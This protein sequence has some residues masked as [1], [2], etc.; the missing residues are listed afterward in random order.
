MK[1]NFF[2]LVIIL[3]PIALAAGC[4]PFSTPRGPVYT[5]QAPPPRPL[6]NQRDLTQNI[7]SLQQ[8]LQE[9]RIS[10][11]DRP[12][13][14]ALLEIYKLLQGA[15]APST[16]NTQYRFLIARIYLR[17]ERIESAF[18]PPR[19]KGPSGERT[20]MDLFSRKRNKILETYLSGDS[21]GVINQ[22]LELK[23][24]FGPGALTP[25]INL[26]FALSLANQGLF[27]EAIET[28]KRTAKELEKS[29]DLIILEGKIA[30]WY[31]RLGQE[32]AAMLRYDKMNDLV[33][34]RTALLSHLK[35]EFH[36]TT[37]QQ[38]AQLIPLPRVIDMVEQKLQAHAFDQARVLL[39]QKRQDTTLSRAER[40]T[41]D[42][43]LD[44]VEK[45]KR[46]SQGR[47][48]KALE[49]IRGLLEKERYE[50][51][52]S[53]LED[54]RSQGIQD[55]ELT[56]LQRAATEGLINRERKKAAALFLR[57]RSAASSLEK[58]EYLRRSHDILQQ[59]LDKFPS[60]PSR[61]RI[62]Q[63]LETVDKELSKW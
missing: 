49:K 10:E 48:K 60:S 46:A 54:L 22:V 29:P 35:Q 55:Y 58:K 39:L 18:Q 51:A 33:D 30:D 32:D 13:A 50:D 37:N 27:K 17:L 52:L 15:S 16:S 2:K 1:A 42:Q 45:A 8:E 4:A 44:R 36:M 6:I 47:E 38:E 23:N 43:A 24:R 25:G 12:G 59:L 61:D 57:A 21:R 3:L 31:S 41:I 14:E 56:D 63:N 40:E 53:L 20:T 26:V 7:L 34:D 28:G 62:L 19:E 9:N 5:A 11:E